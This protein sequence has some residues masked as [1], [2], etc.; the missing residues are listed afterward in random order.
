LKAVTVLLVL[1]V[2]LGSCSG[3]DSDSTPTPAATATA[4]QPAT[5][6][7]E[8]P[9]P[10]SYPDST[11]TGIS[12]VDAVL[13]AVSSAN[14]PQLQSLF[15]LTPSPCVVNPIGIHNPPKCPDGV[16]AGTLIPVFRA[17][18]GEAVWPDY[19]PGALS[20]WL[21]GD[22]QVFA[23]YRTAAPMFNGWIPA[24]DHAIVF[25]DLGRQA[26]P[27]FASEVRVTGGRVTSI[28]F[29]GSSGPERFVEGVPASEFVLPPL[30]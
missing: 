11:R 2:L 20:A 25:A 27:W 4:T 26:E 23:V 29:G 13:D 3:G 18:A 16:S 1:A 22:L 6:T 17:M 28:T 12:E 7:P 10:P 15:E 30:N 9:V 5:A 19:L 8:I 24:A 14:S 21:R